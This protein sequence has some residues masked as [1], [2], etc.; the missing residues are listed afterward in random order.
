MEQIPPDFA[1]G[2]L[3]NV[4]AAGAVGF[5]HLGARIPIAP[6]VAL[7]FKAINPVYFPTLRAAPSWKNAGIHHGAI[8]KS[9]ISNGDLIRS[10][11]YNRTGEVFVQLRRMREGGLHNFAIIQH[12]LGDAFRY[13]LRVAPQIGAQPGVLREAGVKHIQIAGGRPVLFGGTMEVGQR[14]SGEYWIR[15]VNDSGTYGP[16]IRADEDRLQLMKEEIQSAFHYV[17]GLDD[18]VFDAV[19]P[20]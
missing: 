11:N 18:I 2:P 10:I 15:V 3:D 12:K 14:E 1:P 16:R 6:T 17:I 4:F 7:P 20:H 9:A 19:K 13:E 8:T 5:G